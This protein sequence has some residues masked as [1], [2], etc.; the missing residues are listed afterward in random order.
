MEREPLFPTKGQEEDWCLR[1]WMEWRQ[2]RGLEQ[3]VKLPCKPSGPDRQYRD[4]LGRLIGVEV[5][6]V[7]EPSE[8]EQ[9]NVAT[10]FLFQEVAPLVERQLPWAA[11]AMVHLPWKIPQRDRAQLARVVAERIIE[12]AA[13]LEVGQTADCSVATQTASVDLS[14]FRG[15]GQESRLQLGVSGWPAIWEFEDRYVDAVVDAVRS[16]TVRGQMASSEFDHRVLLLHDRMP[17][18]G[19]AAVEKAVRQLSDETLDAFDEIYLI[20]TYEPGRCLRAWPP[21]E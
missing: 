13:T 5:T 17:G 11:F 20:D 8:R 12:A 10:D 14:I 1:K 21:L 6:R 7:L 2:S 16:K 15:S 3:L 4:S 19:H 18:V 9:G